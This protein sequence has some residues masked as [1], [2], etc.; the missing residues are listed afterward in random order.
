MRLHIR[1]CLEGMELK[2]SSVK[3]VPPMRKKL[4]NKIHLSMRALF[5]AT[6]KKKVNMHRPSK[7]LWEKK[8]K[9]EAF[10]GPWIEKVFISDIVSEYLV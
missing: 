8:R 3:Y 1:I 9:K 10:A 6:K 7:V 4:A 5:K 2:L